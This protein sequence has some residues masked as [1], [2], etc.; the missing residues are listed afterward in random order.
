[1]ALLWKIE[2]DRSISIMKDGI[3]GLL[4]HCYVGML[5]ERQA[6]G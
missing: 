4:D 3:S 1:M 6:F 5:Q 2:L